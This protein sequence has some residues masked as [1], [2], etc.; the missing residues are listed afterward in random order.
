MGSDGLIVHTAVC[1][2]C[3]LSYRQLLGVCPRS[4]RDIMVQGCACRLFCLFIL[5]TVR[6]CFSGYSIFGTKIEN[7]PF[8]RAESVGY[9]HVIQKH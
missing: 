5:G 7:P 2:E 6:V 8:F 4:D 9:V 3:R 1:M